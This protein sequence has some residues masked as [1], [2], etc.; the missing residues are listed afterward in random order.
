MKK[1]FS[2][3]LTWRQLLY[4]RLYS[5]PNDSECTYKHQLGFRSLHAVVRALLSKINNWYSDL[6][7]TQRTGVELQI[8]EPKIN[9]LPL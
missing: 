7:E 2:F 9:A 4:D 5:C 3:Y 8:I 6:E 1:H